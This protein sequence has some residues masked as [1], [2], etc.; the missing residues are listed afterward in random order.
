VQENGE[1]DGAV[2]TKAL[3]IMSLILALVLIFSGGV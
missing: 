2:N 3:L 1:R